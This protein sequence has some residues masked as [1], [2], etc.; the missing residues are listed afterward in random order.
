MPSVLGSYLERH[1]DKEEARNVQI[2]TDE[3][4]IDN[5]KALANPLPDIKTTH[6]EDTLAIN[7]SLKRPYCNVFLAICILFFSTCGYYILA[8]SLTSLHRVLGFVSLG[9]QWS[10]WIVSSLLVPLVIDLVGLKIT[11]I[12]GSICYLIFTLCN[13]YPSWYTMIPGSILIGLGYGVMFIATPA[14]INQNAPVIAQGKPGNVEENSNRLI[15]ILQGVLMFW[16][17]LGTA[18]GNVITS[19]FL[20]TDPLFQNSTSSLNQSDVCDKPITLVALS[21]STYYA[22]VGTAAFIGVIPIILAM[23]LSNDHKDG[24][25]KSK[26][27]AFKDMRKKLYSIC[28]MMKKPSYL[29]PLAGAFLP[30]LMGGFYTGS[31]TKVSKKT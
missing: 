16:L 22:I 11:T 27:K 3:V 4:K 24:I 6:T 31:F 17:R 29:L 9:L 28:W 15:S 25:W 19:V 20:F 18:F 21:P 10:A 13:F 23:F 30:G 2:V 5:G 26:G 14:Y 12:A 7:V 1:Q 8:G